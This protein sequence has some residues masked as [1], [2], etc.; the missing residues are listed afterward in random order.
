MKKGLVLGCLVMFSLTCLGAYPLD[1]TDISSIGSASAGLALTSSTSF[2]ANPAALYFRDV[3]D[4]S[5]YVS[6][7][8]TD[9]IVP[10]NFTDGEPSPLVESPVSDFCVSFSGRSL[11]LT[12]EA[13]T[14][15][16]ERTVYSDYTTFVANSST[17]FQLDWAIGSEKVAFGLSLRAISYSERSPVVI[18]SNYTAG[19]YFVETVLG[20]YET[21]E[22]DAIVSAG[23]GILVNYDWFK[24]GVTSDAFAYAQGDDSLAIS[25]DSLFETLRWGFAFSSPT[26]DSTNQLNLFKFE[27]ALDLCDIGNSDTREVRFGLDIKLQLLPFWSVSLNNGYRETKPDLENFF[28]I[29]PENGIH[30][31]GLEIQLNR[32]SLDF[33]CSIPLDW[34][35]GTSDDDSYVAVTLAMSFAV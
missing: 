7:S 19:D 1:H 3:T 5:F 13:Q 15:L 32:I 12:L 22:E 9:S 11:A 23:M 28:A 2:F 4:S 34:Y 26:Y 29:V 8:Y 14:S 17:L 30:T 6:G 21:L 25:A 31:I 24:M 16:T 35:L 20:K 18:R 33:A 10:S 27:S